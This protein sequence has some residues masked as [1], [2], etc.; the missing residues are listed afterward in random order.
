[1]TVSIIIPIFNV[2]VFLRR[3]IDSVLSQSFQDF[4]LIL[5]DDGST[6]NSKSVALEYLR[7]KQIS[8]SL[9][10][11]EN[12]GLSS[13]RNFGL[14]HARGEYVVFVDGDD[15]I[16]EDFLS[17]LSDLIVKNDTDFS[18]CDFSFIKKQEAFDV[19]EADC[20][21]YSKDE[22]L[23]L[24][25][26]RKIGFVV[27]SMLFKKEFLVENVLSF[28]EDIF[29]S[30]DQMFIWD[31]IFASEKGAYTFRKMYGYYIRDNS[32]MTSSSYEKIQNGYE[33]FKKYTDKLIIKHPEYSNLIRIILPRW[34]LGT[35]FTSAN[36]MDKDSFIKLY[37][38]MEGK[39]ILN[40]IKGI[41]EIKAYLL[42]AVS[43]VS[44]N[45]LYA[46]CKGMNLNG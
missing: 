11:K 2:A 42:A 32:I 14:K 39:S 9:Y 22:L 10:E 36:L 25:L 19:A 29:F 17:V 41:N 21:V 23:S 18:F 33:E 24:F 27:P 46:L 30:E 35:L 43:S 5:V 7:D 3:G 26:K 40:R 1:M 44:G 34:Q 4:E 45:L 15:Y 16:S 31:V 28:N 6:D 37:N 38:Q 12:G 13:S 20:T 8:Y